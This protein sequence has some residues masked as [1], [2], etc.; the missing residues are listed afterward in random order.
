MRTNRIRKC[1][2]AGAVATALTL[3]AACGLAPN[4][5]PN[6]SPSTQTNARGPITTTDGDW[7]SVADALG[8]TGKLGDNN[9]AYRV[10]LTRT[11]LHVT[12]YGVAIKPGLSL[13]GYAA[14]ARYDNNETC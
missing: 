9:T 13:G 4:T 5:G 8:R 12:S 1:I 2:V 3:S 7:K 6:T 11:D 14:F 10:T